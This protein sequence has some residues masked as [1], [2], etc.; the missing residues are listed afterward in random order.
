MRYELSPK[1]VPLTPLPLKV[2]VMSP[3]SYGSAA[4]GWG[5]AIAQGSEA[6]NSTSIWSRDEGRPCLQIFT[7][8]MIKIWKVSTAH[9]VILDQ[10]CSG[11]GNGATWGHAPRAALYRGGIGDGAKI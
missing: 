3:S 9:L 7:T 2:G 8:E 5:G 1:Y 6:R 11:D 4:H 10:L